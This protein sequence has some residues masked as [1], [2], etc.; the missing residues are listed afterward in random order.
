M[1]SRNSSLAVISAMLTLL[2]VSH[3]LLHAVS[4]AVYCAVVLQ[5]N[6]MHSRFEVHKSQG[7]S[8][9][10]VYHSR[11]LCPKSN[12]ALV[13]LCVTV[14]SLISF[15]IT[16]SFCFY[17]Q[18]HGVRELFPNLGLIAHTM[19]VCKPCK[20][21]SSS[22][23]SKKKVRRKETNSGLLYIIKVPIV[24]LAPCGHCNTPCFPLAV[25]VSL[26]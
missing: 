11:P 20:S 18:Q 16:T 25:T 24:N 19:T 14:C 15:W 6:P 17:V 12:E 3:Q 2:S 21:L 7:S 1:W 9:E 26:N 8:N 23:P 10:V 4:K 13:M 22:Q 5:T